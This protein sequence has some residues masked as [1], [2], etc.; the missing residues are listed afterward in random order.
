MWTGFKFSNNTSYDQIQSN[1]KPP[2]GGQTPKLF[3]ELPPFW[4]TYVYLILHTT[5]GVYTSSKWK[6]NVFIWL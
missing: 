4:V 6:S 5:W 3:G 2:L 1:K